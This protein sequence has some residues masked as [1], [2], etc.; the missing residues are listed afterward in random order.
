MEQALTNLVL[1]DVISFEE[2]MSKSGK[3]DELQRLIRGATA[4]RGKARR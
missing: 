2:A 1:S 4:S 3:P